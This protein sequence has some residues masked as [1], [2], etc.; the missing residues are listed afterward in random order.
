MAATY[1]QAAFVA[2]T[3]KAG[4]PAVELGFSDQEAQYKQIGLTFGE[5]NIRWVTVPRTGLGSERVLQYWDAMIAA[6]TD[7]LTD[8]E[9]ETGMY[10]PPPDPR[11]AFNGTLR[12]AQAFFQRV[13][14][15]SVCKNCPIALWTDGLPIVIPTEERVARMCTG[16]SH[17]PEEYIAYEQAGTVRF[18]SSGLRM[19]VEAGDPVYILPMMWGTT[20][21]KVAVN[22]VMAGCE[23][24][25]LPIILAAFSTNSAFVTTNCPAAYYLQ[26]SGPIV[27][28]V[29][30][31]VK[32]PY[33]VGI[34]ANMS[35]GRAYNMVFYNI[36]GATQGS[37]NTNLGNP[38]NRTGVAIGEDLD[39]LPPGWE[40]DNVM[41]GAEPNES[42]VRIYANV[43]SSG[44]WVTSNFSPQ[45]F[46]DMNQGK[47]PIARYL[48]VE[49]MPGAYNILEYLI[50]SLVGAQGPQGGMD[51]CILSPDIAMSL[52]NY[53]FDSKAAVNNW[54]ADELY[55]SAGLYRQYGWYDFS[56]G[57]GTRAIRGVDNPEG[58]TYG[59]APDD[60][61]INIYSRGFRNIIVSNSVGE[62]CIMFYGGSN[63]VRMIDPWR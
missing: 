16:T 50:P 38:T 3:E 39:S 62:P 52:Y 35:I 5:P 29:G 55:M 54:L 13:M 41:A 48:G 40:P 57:G 4:I 21:E 9:K 6:L 8:K 12:D 59:N 14:P 26:L 37:A 53:G 1:A 63:S 20:I 19:E 24:S 23:P 56:T 15:V 60:F 17:S 32:D 18:S 25:A 11:I 33:Q 49:G 43:F 31:N 22:C 58:Y 30:L 2:N 45:A 34:P 44:G 36:G 51:A 10:F 61:L 46:K 7:P 47:G 42:V 27:K 28:E